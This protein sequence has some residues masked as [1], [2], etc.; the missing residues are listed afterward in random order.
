MTTSRPDEEAIFKVAF[1]IESAEARAEYLHQICGTDEKLLQRVQVLLAAHEEERS[2]LESPPP[3]VAATVEHATTESAGDLIGPYKLLQKLGEGGMGVV[4]MAEQDEPV[5]RRVALK[6][7][8]PGMDSAQVIARFEAERQALAMMDHPSIAKVFDAGATDSGRPYFVMELVRGIP[9]TQYCDEEHF[10]PRQRLELFLRVCQAVQHAHQKGIIHRDIKPTNV[11]VAEYDQQP[12]PKVIDFGV[13]KATSQ[14]LTEKTMFT[15]FGQIIGTLEY[16][17]PEQA[18]LNQL[19]IDTRSDVYS[20]GVLLYELLTGQTP[21]DRKRLHSAAFE[22]MLRIIQEEE[23]PR[24]STRLSGSNDRLT[25][26]KHRSQTP[27][28]LDKLVRGDLDWIVMKALEKDRGRRY[29]TASSFAT[30]IQRFLS[31]EAISARPPSQAYRTRKFIRRHKGPVSAALSLLVALIAGICGTTIAMIVAIEN[32]RLADDN[33]RKAS[34]NA[35]LASEAAERANQNEQVAREQADTIQLNLY[36]AQMTQAGQAQ[37]TLNGIGR[38]KGLLANWHPV[39]AGRDLRGWEWYYLDSLCH[40]ELI[41]F[42]G[43]SDTVWSVSWSPDGTQLASA[44][45][46]GTVKVWDVAKQQEVL[47]LQDHT[48]SVNSVSWSP[49]GKRIASAGEDHTVKVWDVG[50]ATCVYTLAEHATPVLAVSWSHDGRRLAS[51]SVGQKEESGG[52]VKIWNVATQMCELTLEGHTTPINA[53]AWRPDNRQLASAGGNRLPGTPD[54]NVRIWDAQTGEQIAVLPHEGRVRTVRWSPDGT[55]LASGGGHQRIKIWDP[56]NKRVTCELG[57]AVN[58]LCWS[59]DGT[60]L[61]STKAEEKT[62]YVWDVATGK[63][64]LMRRGHFDA[65]MSLSWAPRSP[66]LASASMDGTVMIWDVKTRKEEVLE[67]GGQTVDVWGLC[68]SP[69]CTRVA[70]ATR[71]GQIDVWNAITGEHILSMAGHPDGIANVK[72]SLNSQQIASAGWDRTI[73]IWDAHTGVEASALAGHA[74]GTMDVAWSPTDEWR[75]ASGGRDNNVKVWDLVSKRAITTLRGHADTVRALCWSPDGTRIASVAWGERHSTVRIW[76]A[77]LGKETM[78]PLPHKGFIGAVSWSPDGTQLASAGQTGV[79]KGWNA[80]TGDVEFML[81]GHGGAVMSLSWSPEG[82]RIASAD[83]SGKIKIWDPATE[84]ETLMLV[85]N[86]N[87]NIVCWS[88]DGRRLA[89]AG[90]RPGSGLQ[91]IK[92]WDATVAYQRAQHRNSAT[93]N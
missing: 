58:S 71:S 25:I 91:P 53:V 51:A 56:E 8:K 34:A 19:D 48:G 85:A 86:G 73:K 29:E 77:G 28:R 84:N 42:T 64:T 10:T 43:H 24:P 69:D 23:P 83:Y 22:E 12:V 55:R 60:Q 20:L 17:S 44:G 16:M 79:I 52:S 33:A 75:L 92:V 30:D 87:T 72:W 47:S 93:R 70:S 27:D 90:P 9:I 1:K 4:Y 2:F 49:D 50:L 89:T 7:I 46:D 5:T 15:Q 45:G 21:F 31:D 62:I 41:S 81:Y 61:A 6:V 63:H 65:V 35:E 14:K 32:K 68:W 13:A 74:G 18:R 78:P 38:V 39:A 11:L 59:P 82:E 88:P 40:Q 76:N 67:F 26:A 57:D 54:Q 37:Q 3:A 80:D 36:Y 66:Q